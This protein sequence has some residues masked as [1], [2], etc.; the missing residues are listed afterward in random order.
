MT[1]QT[2]Y[3]FLQEEINDNHL[4][5]NG[6]FG[7]RGFGDVKSRSLCNILVLLQK[8]VLS[9]SIFLMVLISYLGTL[10]GGFGSHGCIHLQDISCMVSDLAYRAHKER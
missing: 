10:R 1:S 2:S 9:N 4:D 8:F 7:G 5:N 6:Q 3:N